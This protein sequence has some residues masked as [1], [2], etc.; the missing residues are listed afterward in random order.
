MTQVES[1]VSLVRDVLGDDLLGAYLHGSAVLGRLRPRSDTDVLVVSRRGLTTAER[2]ALTDGIMAISGRRAR[3]GPARPIELTVVVQSEVRPWRYP[4]R[5]EFLYGEWLRDGYERGEVPEAEES[6]DLAPLISMVLLGDRPLF[7]PPPSE[8][9]D[10]VPRADLVRAVVHGVPGLLDDLEPDT[11]NVLLTLARIW[12]TVATGEIRA[13]DAA[14]D[15]V[16]GRLPEVHRPVLARARAVYLG[17]VED[18]QWDDLRSR[19][20]PHADFVIGEIER[21]VAATATTDP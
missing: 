3:A 21:A 10:P 11:A 2:L 7:G 9:L 16:L 12:T 19:L 18:E 6:P 13:K 8:V 14:A 15:W 20:R 5:S 1:I 17:E 4:P